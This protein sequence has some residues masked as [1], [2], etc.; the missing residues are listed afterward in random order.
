VR[1]GLRAL[2]SVSTVLLLLAVTGVTTCRQPDR[3]IAVGVI[4]MLEGPNA[5]NGQNMRDA[6]ALAVKIVNGRGGL[7]VGR[8][9]VKVALQ[10]END[11]NSPVGAL[12]AA[13]KL[14]SLQSVVALVGPQFSGNA[15]PVA[16]L[17]ESSRVV[18]I[19]PLSTN[20]ETTANKSFV[21]RIPYL[22]TF[23]GLV[24]ARF[25]REK[26]GASRAAVLYDVAE[27]YNR[28][29]A[30]E[31][32]REF[33]KRGGTIKCFE[34]YTTD[35]N[36][37]FTAQLDHIRSE[38][39]DVLFLPNY[40]S[41]VRLQAAQARERGITAVL[42]GGDGW[43]RR[44]ARDPMFEGSY[45]TWQWDPSLAVGPAAAFVS[46]FREAYGRE[47]EDV[48]ASTWDSFGILF[49][50]IE[51]GNSTDP[52]AI[53]TALHGLKGYQG[54]TGRIGYSSGGDPSKN[55]VILKLS[56]GRAS[57]YAVVEP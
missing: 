50:A 44:F 6:A 15:I 5:P 37:S 31:F 26:L 48:A 34:T 22:D 19:A 23:Q 36:T 33:E 46:A 56:Q 13:R 29:L 24:I 12:D 1:S 52:Q 54:V 40:A 55:A 32:R 4:A 20:P 8:G 27:D 45:A 57:L 39:P 21:F 7:H 28:T 9:M 2:Q 41:D 3:E 43:D 18:M 25:A 17:A 11:P 47:P 53:K 16:R 14:L 49:A 35:R 30:E 38:K 51:A 10:V 42:L